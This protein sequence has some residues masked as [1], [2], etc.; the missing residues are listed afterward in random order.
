VAIGLGIAALVQI[1]RR[2]QEGKGMAIAGLVIGSVATIG[3]VLLFGLAI[4]FGSS[5]DDDYGAPEPVTSTSGPTTY[6]DELVVGE[7][8]D[9][10]GTEEDE[11][12]RQ[13]CTMEHDGE[14]VAIV[15]LPGT[16][17]PGDSAIDDLAEDACTPAF[18]TYVGKSSDDSE[19]TL[20]WWTPAKSAWNHGDHRVLCAAFAPDDEKLTSTVKNSHR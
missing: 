18:G 8:F 4:A 20:D 14:I 16:T 2:G 15:T 19:L 3:Y 12:S 11:V 6:V 9:D 1:K 5:G 10:D 7:C 17:Y 13:P